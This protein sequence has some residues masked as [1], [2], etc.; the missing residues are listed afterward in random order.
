MLEYILFTATAVPQCVSCYSTHY[1]QCVNKTYKYIPSQ[2]KINYICATQD[3]YNA[4]CSH[5]RECETSFSFAEANGN[6]NKCT[7][8]RQ[9]LPVNGREVSV[10]AIRC[11]DVM[12]CFWL[13]L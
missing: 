4:F 5:V 3:L 2:K 1:L 13:T 11:S 12:L 9:T 10:R 8:F 6:G 7:H